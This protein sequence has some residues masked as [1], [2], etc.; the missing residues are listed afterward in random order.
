MKRYAILAAALIILTAA[1]AGCG[2]TFTGMS[3]DVKRVG[4]GVKTIFFRDA[5]Q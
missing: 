2:E 1:L 4:K 3:K 5:D